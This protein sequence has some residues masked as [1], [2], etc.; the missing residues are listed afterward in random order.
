MTTSIKTE[1]LL[2]GW[3]LGNQVAFYGEDAVKVAAILGQPYN[4]TCR[5]KEA[6]TITGR[7]QDTAF[8]K[9]VRAGYKLAIREID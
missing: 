8:P 7:Y 4:L 2:I 9:L 3:E 5:N 6:I 1:S